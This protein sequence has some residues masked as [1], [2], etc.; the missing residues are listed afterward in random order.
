ME[1]SA[2]DAPRKQVRPEKSLSLNTRDQTH[3]TKD[4]AN[5]LYCPETSPP[6]F[7]V[8]SSAAEVKGDVLRA[9]NKLM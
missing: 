8:E 7:A 4:Y 6:Y 1:R 3:V 5:S 2:V 9:D